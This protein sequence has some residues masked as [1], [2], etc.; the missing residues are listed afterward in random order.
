M[1]SI[2]NS[3]NQTAS[4]R[5][6]KWFY[7]LFISVN[8]LLSSYYLDVWIT[9][10]AT[11]RALPVLTLYENKT[12]QIDKYKDYS[13][14]R[15]EVKGH[16]YSDK[17]PLGTFLVYPFYYVYKSIGL[18][19]LKDSSLTKYPIYIYAYK[20]S[21]GDISF[22]D[23]RLFFPL[24]KISTVF[25]L[26][27]ILCG[28]LPFTIALFLALLAASKA[29]SEN[30]KVADGGSTSSLF[31]P[32]IIVMF[33][34][35][36]SFL[37]AYAGTFTGHIL[38]GLF[39]LSGY[40]FIKKK[41]YL[42]AGLMIGLAVAAEFTVGILIPLWAILIYLNERKITKPVFFMAGI[43]PGLLFILLYNLHVT[44]NMLLT[45]YSYLANSYAGHKDIGFTHPRGD[46]LWGM[47][48]SVYRGMLFYAPVLAVLLWYVIK[49][50]IKLLKGFLSGKAK[51]LFI[52][53]IKNYLL[54]TIIIYT[55]LISSYFMWD[56][57]WAF[58]PR[59]IIPLIFICLYEG[60]SFLASKKI[61]AYFFYIISGIG[62]LF[63]WMDKSTKIYEIPNDSS[64]FSNPV[65][66]III[67]DFLKHK[68]NTNLLP[69][70][71]F[72]SNPVIAIYVWPVLFMAGLFILTRGY[73]KVHPIPKK[74]INFYIP[75]VC[76]TIVYA[77]LLMPRNNSWKDN[78]TVN[79]SGMFGGWDHYARAA[80][81]TDTARNSKDSVK[82]SQ[83]YSL[84]AREYK[85][86]T[87]LWSGYPDC[88][89]RLGLC[90]E[91]EGYPDSAIVAFKNALHIAPKF[92]PPA[93]YLG[94]IY[95]QRGQYDTA[96]HYFNTLDANDPN[97]REAILTIAKSFE[98]ENKY[99]IASY[100]YSLA[101][102]L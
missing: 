27:D 102:R 30:N 71:M 25:I 59:Q 47:I 13:L 48:F 97:N 8:L 26:A 2:D 23:G 19:E 80:Q 69:V 79:T 99:E 45:P 37:F 22:P 18:P 24:P 54:V 83:Y 62:L 66:D 100:Y 49:Q 58:G 6:R 56:G 81:F 34:F 95:L 87:K 20:F 96:V 3:Y 84:A 90:Y 78:F 74:K 98:K 85:T 68:F 61:S 50:N 40:I 16:Y 77:I 33:S 65:F 52:V 91:E 53:G 82:K 57:G 1:N 4:G 60:A 64:Q 46:A 55:L 73:S 15:S 10:N 63:V 41:N 35:Y 14:D 76:L 44:G 43:I 36:A 12:I 51:E 89:L 9:P 67:P 7:A 31:S 5:G 11:S 39:A 28:S 75:A 21:G 29:Y 72:D 38:S 88:F 86:T 92:A 32:V 93:N 17:A 42:F 101:A 94:M 70:F